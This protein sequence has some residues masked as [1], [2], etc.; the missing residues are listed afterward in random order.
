VFELNYALQL[1]PWWTLQLDLRYM[2]HPS[3]DVPDPSNPTNATVVRNTFI[4][5]SRS[6]TKF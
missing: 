2:V 6:A 3:G 4:A 1:A 5:G